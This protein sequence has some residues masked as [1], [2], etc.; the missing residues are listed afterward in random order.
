MSKALLGSII[1]KLLTGNKLKIGGLDG[2]ITDNEHFY[3]RTMKISSWV[4][5]GQRWKG[6]GM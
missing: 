3:V 6:R 5:A 4:V 2:K 1:L